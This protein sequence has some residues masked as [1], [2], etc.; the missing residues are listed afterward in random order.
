MNCYECLLQFQ[1]LTTRSNNNCVE[2]NGAVNVLA[3]ITQHLK[4]KQICDWSLKRSLVLRW[5]LKRLELWRRTFPLDERPLLLN[6]GLYCIIDWLI[7]WKITRIKHRTGGW[8]GSALR[9]WIS[10]SRFWNRF[11]NEVVAKPCGETVLQE[12]LCPVIDLHSLVYGVL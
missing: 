4:G 9:W 5:N 11:R 2:L 7:S 3:M 6:I 1:F 8:M 10:K 12:Q